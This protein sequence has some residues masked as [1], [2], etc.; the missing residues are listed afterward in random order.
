M[1]RSAVDLTLAQLQ[2][3]RR[4]G[5]LVRFDSE[6]I[7]IAMTKAF[8]AVGGGETAASSRMR[9]I[10]ARLA[11]D[12]V[13]SLTRRLPDGGAVHIEDIQDQVELAL[14]RAGEHD[15]A[16]AY[17]LYREKRAVERAERAVPAPALHVVDGSLRR[18]LDMA[19]LAERVAAT[20][21]GVV[22][23]DPAQVVEQALKSLY[24]GVTMPEVRNALILAA[25]TQIERDPGYNRVAARLMLQV[26]EREA[27]GSV[28]T[29][30]EYFP[31]FVAQGIEAGLLDA[32][33][34]EFDLSR[35][36]AALKPERDAQFVDFHPI[37][38]RGFH[39]KLTH[40]LCA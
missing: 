35:L 10:V 30:D 37:L 4:N 2:V 31:L 27:L 19:E 23:V 25:R 7:V 39:L 38:T 22:E 32:R 17:V 3:I 12:V 24:D 16:K 33:L 14:M 26:V 9:D 11:A 36:A 1:D 21:A 20:C 6:K 5:D 28:D 40:G 13:R 8:L 29:Q 15:V 34:A 18:P